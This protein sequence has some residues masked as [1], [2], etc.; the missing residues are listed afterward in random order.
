MPM[1]FHCHDCDKPTPNFSVV[2]DKCT[3]KREE[4]KNMSKK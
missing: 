1:L 2:C 3:K 4:K